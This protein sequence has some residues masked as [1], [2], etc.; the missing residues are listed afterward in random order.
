MAS[1]PVLAGLVLGL[2]T[3]KPQFCI[4]VPLASARP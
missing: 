2:L 1:R 4:L 3:F